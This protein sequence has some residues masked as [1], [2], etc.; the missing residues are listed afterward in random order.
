MQNENK[1]QEKIA[2]LQKQ[3]YDKNKK[4]SIFK[5]AQKLDCAKHVTD[6]I[7]LETLLN[8]TF[9]I[10]E[11][12]NIIITDYLVFKTF[13]NPS[14]YEQIVQYTLSLATYCIQEFGSYALQVNLQSFTITAAQ[15]HSDIIKI[16]CE[17]CLRKESVLYKHLEGMYVYNYPTIISSL[18]K[19]FTPF[20]DKEA[21]GK[22]HLIDEKV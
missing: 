18:R 4:N 11:N 14:N 3:Y 15:R 7:S 17:R 1:I 19:L 6:N 21:L 22:V 10:K 12:T 8:K 2:Q 13:A 5:S 16:L 20:F 9:Y